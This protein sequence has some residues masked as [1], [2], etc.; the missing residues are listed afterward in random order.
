MGTSRKVARMAA[1]QEVARMGTR[2]DLVR[3]RHQ[4]AVASGATQSR[5]QDE[6]RVATIPTSTKVMGGSNLGIELPP[7][8][9]AA[10]IISESRVENFARGT[11]LRPSLACQI[12]R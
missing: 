12:N 6:T 7:L 3:S 9:V 11:K 8:V 10:P 2:R 4:Q 5:A 1:R